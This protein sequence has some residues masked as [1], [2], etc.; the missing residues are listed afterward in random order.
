[1]FYS[2]LPKELYTVKGINKIFYDNN[3]CILHKFLNT[4][5]LDQHKIATSHC[6]V[7]LKKGKLVIATTTGKLL[8]IYENEMLFMPRDTYLISDYTK[9]KGYIELFM[10]FFDHNLIL[11]FLKSKSQSLKS[12]CNK[13]STICQ[14]E[15]SDNIVQ[16]FSALMTV[17]TNQK[18]EGGILEIKV[19]EFLHLVYL[20]NGAKIINTLTASENSNRRRNLMTLMSENYDKNLSIIDFAQL[21]GRS[22]ST[23][24]RDFKRKYKQTP[25]QW[26]I[27]KKMEKA[28]ELLKSGHTVTNCALDLGYNNISHFIKAY[29]VYYGTT[30]KKH[31]ID[32]NRPLLTFFE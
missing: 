12:N 25:K 11:K 30:P 17:Y 26:L 15:T 13:K 16:Y 20:N 4:D 9:D 22:L 19:L 18:N 2:T 27:D 21:S 23:F 28:V 6:I 3:S 14:L 5:L 24:N 1:M 29:K 8:T 31:A 32:L 7:Y 10:V